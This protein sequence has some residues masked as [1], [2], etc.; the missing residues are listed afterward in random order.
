M[1]WSR[2]KREFPKIRGY[3]IFGVVVIKVLRFRVLY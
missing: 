2:D 3:I 1:V